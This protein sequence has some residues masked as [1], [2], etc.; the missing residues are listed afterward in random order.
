MVPAVILA[1]GYSSRMGRDKALL[2]LPGGG[3]FVTR[4]VATF[5]AAG[6]D[7]VTVVAGAT[8]RQIAAAVADARL[9]VRVVVNPDP[10]RGQLSSLHV[11][12]AALPMPPPLALLVAPVDLPLIAVET[13]RTIVEAWSRSRAP[14]VRPALGP[15]HGHPVLFDARVF[16]ELR[17]A[18][19]SAGA[20]VV[21]R[22]HADAAQDVDVADPGAYDDIDTPEDYLRVLG[23]GVPPG[24]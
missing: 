22:A 18:P 10:A 9:P 4:L 15:R 12:L 16:P 2:P 6:C 14:I 7:D 11:A 20:R 3:C 23:V 5:L 24:R 19:L 13:V 21:V 17:A 8:A 1:A